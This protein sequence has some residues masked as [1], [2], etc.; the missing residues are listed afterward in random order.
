MTLRPFLA[1]FAGSAALLAAIVGSGI[2]AAQLCAGDEGLM[3]LANSLATAATLAVVIALLGPVSGAHL[4]PAVTALAW[5]EGDLPG[6]RAAGYVLAQ[7]T[8]AVTGV[9]LAHALFGVALIQAGSKPRAST[10]LWLSEFLATVALLAVVRACR[11]ESAAKAAATV[12]LTVLA[13]YWVTSSTFFANPAVTLARAL[14]DSFAGIRP[15][16]APAYVIAQ[17][18]GLLLVLLVVRVVL[19]VT[20]GRTSASRDD[21]VDRDGGR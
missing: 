19:S 16:D 11:G 8:G 13:G 9:L 12:S 1:E 5:A 20:G 7:L 10:G 2:M 15:S 18:A 6:S 17:L 4:N 14:T 3:L 21:A